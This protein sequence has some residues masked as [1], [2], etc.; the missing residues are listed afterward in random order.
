[1]TNDHGKRR[2]WVPT[3]P[4]LFFESDRTIELLHK[5]YKRFNPV[6]P[7][8]HTKHKGAGVVQKNERGKPNNHSPKGGLV[9]PAHR[10][11]S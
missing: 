4:Q 2:G 3:I 5:K 8:T 9:N 10:S 11:L 1:M 7:H 6:N